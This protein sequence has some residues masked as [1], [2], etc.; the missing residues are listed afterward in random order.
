M[1]GTDSRFKHRRRPG[2]CGAIGLFQ[3]RRKVNAPQSRL[4]RGQDVDRFRN[5]CLRFDR[6]YKLY[7][8][9]MCAR[10]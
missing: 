3:Y 4:G 9:V 7:I 6:P 1:A 8:S 10:V 2:V 5:S